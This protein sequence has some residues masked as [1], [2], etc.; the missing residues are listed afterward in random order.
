MQPTKRFEASNG[1]YE[2]DDDDNDDTGT[3]YGD[4]EEDQSGKDED[5]DI[6]PK[7]LRNKKHQKNSHAVNNDGLI[8]DDAVSP[9]SPRKKGNKISSLGGANANENINKPTTRPKSEL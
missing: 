7:T 2:D 3:C 8:F 4:E 9:K 6:S 5:H 1:S